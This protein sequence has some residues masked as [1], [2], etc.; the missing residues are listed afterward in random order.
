MMPLFQEGLDKVLAE[1]PDRIYP[2][3]DPP[4]AVINVPDGLVGSQGQAI[5]ELSGTLSYASPYVLRA[6]VEARARAQLQADG[7]ALPA[8]TTLLPET[9]GVDLGP[10]T[11]NGL[12]VSVQVSVRADAAPDVDTEQLRELAA[13]KTPDEV[14]TALEDLGDVTVRLWPDWVDRVPRLEWR[15]EIEL[16]APEGASPGPSAAPSG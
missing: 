9:I 13:G 10:A 8:G 4:A 11:L 12:A 6:D 3:M 14:T 5:F 1:D 7:D 15:I 2:P 16:A